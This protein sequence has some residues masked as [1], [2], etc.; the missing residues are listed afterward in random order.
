MH[1]DMAKRVG[2]LLISPA[3]FILF[4]FQIRGFR[5]EGLQEARSFAPTVLFRILHSF[6][7]FL[8]L[9][10][11]FSDSFRL[12]LSLSLFHAIISTVIFATAQQVCKAPFELWVR[13]HVM[14][15]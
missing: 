8:S 3:G 12:S 7:L 9:S 15:F 10:L 6:L 11:P 2:W 14:G 5:D 4:D 1:G 13:H